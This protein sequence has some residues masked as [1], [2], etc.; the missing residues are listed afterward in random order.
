VNDQLL[1]PAKI[2]LAIIFQS[3]MNEL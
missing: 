2:L 3:V 1:E